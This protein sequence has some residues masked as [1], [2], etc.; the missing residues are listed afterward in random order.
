M[1]TGD[2]VTAGVV[3]AL[4]TEDVVTGGVVVAGIIPLSMS[5]LTTSKSACGCSTGDSPGASGSS[6]KDKAS[7]Q[8]RSWNEHFCSIQLLQSKSKPRIQAR[9][10]RFFPHSA[11]WPKQDTHSPKSSG[12]FGE[13]QSTVLRP[14]PQALVAHVAYAL[15]K[16]ALL[17]Q[18]ARS[19]AVQDA[20]TVAARTRKETN[21]I[22]THVRRKDG[23]LMKSH[24]VLR[25]TSRWALDSTEV[26]TA[27]AGQ[28]RQR[29]CT[30]T[31]TCD[32]CTSRYTRG[33]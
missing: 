22:C 10:Q 26:G 25:C 8:A 19:S 14:L 30:Q 23:A 32:N 5:I 24:E 33:S 29:P 3:A 20:L 16:A 6:S 18:T 9:M 4:V 11:V 17:N 1:V 15:E 12:Y 7:V 27:A 31:A 13:R 21:N 2:V 28:L